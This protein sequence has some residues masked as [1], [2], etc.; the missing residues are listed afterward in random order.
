MHMVSG[1]LKMLNTLNFC[2]IAA[3]YCKNECFP[4]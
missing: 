1:D 2:A 4:I 3:A